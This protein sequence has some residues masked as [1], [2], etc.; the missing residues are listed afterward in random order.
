MCLQ[1]CHLA[2]T[3]LAALATTI[4]DLPHRPNLHP[5]F[6]LWLT[7]APSPAIPTSILAAGPTLVLEPPKGL[8]ARL[9]HVLNAAPADVASPPSAVSQRRWSRVVFSVALFHAAVSERCR[10]G[11]RAWGSQCEFTPGDLAAT[12]SSLRQLV[13]A[14]GRLGGDRRASGGSNAGRVRSSAADSMAA[15][16]E[17]L[18]GGV[19]YGGRVTVER[20]HALLT[21]MLRKYVVDVVVACTWTL[22]GADPEG[23]AGSPL[24]EGAGALDMK[25]LVEWAA[26]APGLDRVECLGLDRSAATELDQ[27]ARPGPAFCRG[28]R[29]C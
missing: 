14:Y 23:A 2:E 10:F 3:S 16:I 17:S 29:V 26:V 1:N 4:S 25:G 13:V 20:D 12:V 7:L 21:C 8:C 19:H 9:M 6:R 18:V 5:E 28:D 11:P 15:A 24:L 27:Q 22:P